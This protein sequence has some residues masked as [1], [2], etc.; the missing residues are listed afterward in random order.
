MLN[1]HNM[2]MFNSKEECCE[3]FYS[4]DYYACAGTTPVLTNGEF[5]PDWSGSTD[6]TC[7]AD[8]KAP[9]YMLHNQNHYLAPT[10]EKCCKKHFSWDVK[11]CLGDSPGSTYAGTNKWYVNWTDKKCVQDCNSG[12]APCGG[13][14]NS[15]DDLYTSQADCCEEKLFWI[16]TRD[17]VMN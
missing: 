12:A 16:N 5:Y 17:C 15:W 4:W 6:H 2:F 11:K 8:G 10:L 9:D 13:I 14:A 1:N 7:I 3:N